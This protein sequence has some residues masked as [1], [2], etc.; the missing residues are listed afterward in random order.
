[1]LLCLFIELLAV[2]CKLLM[3]KL[4]ALVRCVWH[5]L[6]ERKSRNVLTKEKYEGA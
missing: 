2:K 3:M 1:M 4:I 5:E 6:V